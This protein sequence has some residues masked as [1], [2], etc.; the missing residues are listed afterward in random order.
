MKNI[1]SW[2]AGKKTESRA[3]SFDGSSDS[4]GAPFV[5]SFFYDRR[6]RTKNETMEKEGGG[7]EQSSRERRYFFYERCEMLRGREL[8]LWRARHTH[9]YTKESQRLI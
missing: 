1:R 9:T 6:G 7:G 4:L 2:S 5:M 3:D 8:K